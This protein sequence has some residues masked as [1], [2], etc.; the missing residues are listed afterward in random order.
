MKKPRDYQEAAHTALMSYIHSPENYGKNP[1]VVEATGLGKSL[2]ISMFIWHMMTKYPALRIMQLC[3]V[4]E[5]VEGNCRELLGMWPVAPVGVYAAGLGHRETHAPITFAMI[6]SVHRRAA[7]FGKVD[8]VIIDEAHRLSENDATMYGTFL[9]ALRV[10]NPNL[11]VVGYT[12][13]PFRMSQGLLVDGDLFDEV[14]Y[15]I[16]SGDSFVWAIEQGYLIRPVPVDPG[17]KVDDSGIGLSGGDFKSEDASRAMHEQDI[18]ERAVDYTVALAKAQNRQ[19]C[20]TFAQSISDCELIADMYTYKGFPS[21][22]V[23][24]NRSDRD[25]VLKAFDKGDLWGAVNRD[26]MTTGSN[27]PRIDLMVALRLTR[28]PGLWVQMVGRGTRPSWVGHLGHNGGPPLYDINTREGRVASILASHKQNTV[29][30]D[31]VGNTERLGPINYPNFPKRR[32]AGGGD[33]P[34]RTCS[35]EKNQQGCA[36]ATYHHVS[37]KVCPECGYEWPVESNISQSA[38]NREIVVDFSTPLPPPVFDVYDVHDMVMTR[39]T[40][41]EGKLDTLRVDYRC[42]YRTFKAWIC[43][44]H[45]VGSFPHVKAEQWWRWHNGQAMPASIDEALELASTLTRPK[46]LQVRTDTKFDEITGYD[47]VGTRFA[48]DSLQPEIF[49]PGPDPFEEIRPA[50]DQQQRFSA[51]ASEMFPEDEI[52]F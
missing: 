17:F 52:P 15:D 23:H 14:V 13:T 45:K 38:S 6:N 10:K 50:S 44:E 22:A 4:K 32:G 34:V 2:N 46:F 8:F 35:Y 33:A 41:K 31:F 28:S 18:I 36:P 11:I 37:V 5:L 48:N 49:E 16:G 20:L 12:A 19:C 3:H 1:L 27:H 39:N 30:L 40:G 51:L 25:D 21:E 9:A 26:V 42:G 24:S 29:M 43:I 47:F 7:S